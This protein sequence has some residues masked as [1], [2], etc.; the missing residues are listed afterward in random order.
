MHMEFEI[1]F[2]HL[3]RRQAFIWVFLLFFL[4]LSLM[5]KIFL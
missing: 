3:F 5:A 1:A 2:V 4:L